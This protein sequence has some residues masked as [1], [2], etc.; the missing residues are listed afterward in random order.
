MGKDSGGG[1]GGGGGE[2]VV[3][4]A[5]YL[6]VAHGQM[7]NH[8]G[9]DVN[10]LSFVD[11]L[12]ATFNSGPYGGYD[13]I[14]VNEGY[15]GITPEDA[16]VTYEPRNF[17]ALWDMFGKFM[18][19]L[20]V[21]DLWAQVYQDVIQGP[22]VENSVAAQAAELQTN[23]DTTVMPKFVAGMRDI[24][25]VQS[26]AFV[27]GKAII[28]DSHVREINKFSAQVRMH[29]LNISVDLWSKHLEWS[30]NV[31]TV[32]SEM[33][34]LYYTSRL[35]LDR[36]NLE[37]Q[38]KDAMWNIN[39]FENARAILGAL[40]A[41]QATGGG[42]TPNEPSQLQK[43]LG[44]AMSGA[45]AGAMVT[46]GNPIGAVVGGVLGLAASFL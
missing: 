32:Y 20:D 9:A 29:T 12:N 30:K 42:N 7:L 37:Y 26:S 24:N 8:A 27:I 16:S 39:L 2:S 25:A 33:F 18:A 1:G 43:S 34:K 22:E 21:H 19:G 23:I 36:A 15:F 17:P 5:P 11:A 44:G 13:L 3:R 45:A 41:G 35:D 14:E 31:I 46:G 40:G 28:A 4:Y 6:E 38:A 10:T